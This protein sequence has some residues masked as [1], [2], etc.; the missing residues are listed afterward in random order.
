MTAGMDHEATPM[1][2]RRVMGQF[3]SGITVVAGCDGDEPVGF[4][5]QS[6][7]SVS[8]E[9]PLVLFCVASASRSWPRIQ[10]SGSFAVNVLAEDQQEICARFGRSGEDKF[11]GLSWR[12][13]EWGP[14]ID[15]V[16]ATVLC[17][18]ETV[19]RA[20]DHDVVIGRVR[21]LWTAGE[22][23]PLVYF[24]GRY[25]LDDPAQDA[26]GLWRWE[27]LFGFQ[28]SDSFEQT[29]KEPAC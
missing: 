6:F 5:C 10:A 24:R 27:A 19:H 2:M 7:A 14:S 8:L 1:E 4:A 23:G 9:P 16:L 15:G 25:G 21:Q 12:R 28:G 11:A 13:T 3:C 18:I 22:N 20:G 26:L 29:P 17:D